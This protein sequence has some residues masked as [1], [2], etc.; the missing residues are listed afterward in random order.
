MTRQP[1]SDDGLLPEPGPS[2]RLRLL[3]Q[4]ARSGVPGWCRLLPSTAVSIGLHLLLLPFALAMTVT[5]A[6]QLFGPPTSDASTDPR[7]LDNDPGWELEL[8]R[9]YEVA[10][11]GGVTATVSE[12]K[13][14][15]TSE[16]RIV[17]G[18]EH[19]WVKDPA[20]GQ[21]RDI[22]RIIRVL[23][24][25]RGTPTPP[26]EPVGV[27]PGADTQEALLKECSGILNKLTTV[28]KT[29]VNE[30]TAQ[31]ALPEIKKILP[32]MEAFLERANKLA[33]SEQQMDE[34][35]KKLWEKY[36]I[37]IELYNEQIWRV[38]VLPLP[39]NVLRIETSD[40]GDTL[41]TISKP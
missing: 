19:Y 1:A 2:E 23:K 12:S 10:G 41:G 40:G 35:N 28:L 27:A 25:R 36:Q 16:V 29:V 11:V 30:N 17:A 37:E 14:A 18:D 22:V 33:P 15:E 20:T 39:T 8:D 24:W 6:D 4:G 5:F 32:R 31:A 7:N 3:M 21:Y 9:D 34:L 38:R 13:S 26:T